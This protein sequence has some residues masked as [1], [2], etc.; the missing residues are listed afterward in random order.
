MFPMRKNSLFGM[1]I[2]HRILVA[3]SFKKFHLT[4]TTQL[5]IVPGL[6]LINLSTSRKRN[7][8][9]ISRNEGFVGKNGPKNS[10]HQTENPFAL[11]RIKN[12]FQKQVSTRRE[13]AITGRS[14]QKIDKKYGFYW[15]ENSF[16]L[17]ALQYSFKNTFL[18]DRKIKISVAGESINGRKE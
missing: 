10:S 8:V 9:S 13:K 17:I 6:E 15:P 18:L 11:A 2:F 16:P 14:I 3:L 1:Y 4:Y 12:L 5:K 7:S